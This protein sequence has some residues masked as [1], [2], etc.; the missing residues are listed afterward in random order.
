MNASGSPGSMHLR[1]FLRFAAL[2]LLIGGAA[3]GDGVAAQA[4]EVAGSPLVAEQGKVVDTIGRETDAL[5]KMMAAN[6]DEDARLVDIRLKLEVLAHD[7]LAAGQAFRPRLS[8]INGRID[9]LGP[10]PDKDQPAEPGPVNAERQA[11]LTEKATINALLG[12]AETCRSAS[13][14]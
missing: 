6:A 5:A 7:L 9:Q 10:A 12:G 3:L 4:D 14:A 2:L 13:T 1:S 8:E 11:L